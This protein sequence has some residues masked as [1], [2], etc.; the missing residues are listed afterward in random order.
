[1]K[2]LQSLGETYN[3]ALSRNIEQVEQ[4]VRAS[5]HLPLLAVGSGGSFTSALYASL[6]H[7]QLGLLSKA[8]TPLEF[9][10]SR[11]SFRDAAVTM[12]T[13]G[14][15]NFDII[16][17]LKKAISDEPKSILVLCGSK[18]SKIAKIAEDYDWVS[19]T[20]LDIPAGRDGFLATNSLIAFCMIMLRAYQKVVTVRKLPDSLA[21]LLHSE[22]PNGPLWKGSEIDA[23]SIMATDTLV[24]L[25]GHWGRPAAVDMESKCTEAALNNVQLADYRNFA[26][27]RH[28][29]LA[30]N[31][32]RSGVLAFVTPEEATLAA[33]TLSLLPKQVP[34]LEI[35]AESPD[36]VGALELIVKSMYLTSVSGKIRGIDPGRPG[37]PEFGRRIYNLRIGADPMNPSESSFPGSV[38][39]SRKI[40]SGRVGGASSMKRWR[41][42]FNNFVEK[43]SSQEFGGVVFDYDGTLCEPRNRFIG[44]SSEIASELTRL[45]ARDIMIGVATGR[46]KSVRNDLRNA[47]DKKLWTR[48]IVGY[49]NGS[50]LGNLNDESHPKSGLVPNP[51]IQQAR[52]ALITSGIELFV[53]KMEVRPSQISLEPRSPLDMDELMPLINSFIPVEV[54]VR[55]LLSSHSIDVVSD[56]ATKLTVVRELERIL[57]SKAK[58]RS[59][60]CIGDM[61]EWPGNDY[62]LL[63]GNFGLSVDTVSSESANLLEPSALGGKRNM[64]HD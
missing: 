58:S 8:S 51:Q 60:L 6:L 43:L 4:F 45:A 49:Y 1:M 44:L 29:W 11:S 30:K 19:V 27:G 39:V 23:R 5:R 3:W 48:V 9:I 21:S 53:D 35:K 63:S 36:A 38:A 34:R 22:N 54:P 61:G 17:C 28:H 25:H 37:V 40:H 62:E 31:A 16:N 24:V 47:L 13:A 20:E 7:E 10:T 15:R 52:D 59:V 14:G 56:N 33:R 18:G 41:I 12:F 26:H 2:E 55:V 32:S 50:D 57:S 64:C 42:A 46:G